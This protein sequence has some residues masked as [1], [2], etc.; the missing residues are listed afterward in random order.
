M[1][2]INEKI[3]TNNKKYKTLSLNSSMLKDIKL[4][5]LVKNFE[6]EMNEEKQLKLVHQILLRWTNTENLYLKDENHWKQKVLTL[7]QID[8][9]NDNDIE[10][11]YNKIK[12]KIYAQLMKNTHL[13][14]YY[15]LINKKNILSYDLT[16]LY[17]KLK[18]D[19]N[20]NE[21]I[22]L[23]RL[24]QVCR[25][26]NGLGIKICKNLIYEIKESR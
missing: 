23:R 14:E 19:I 20:E 22:G 5:L 4:Q 15:N 2:R 6:L 24:N 3:K 12:E 8:F 25:M 13:I 9:K 1:K 26:L 17:E 10:V 7:F 11:E 16:E 21:E 18:R